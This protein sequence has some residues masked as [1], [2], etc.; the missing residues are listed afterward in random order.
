MA[1]IT[2]EGFYR[3]D[4]YGEA[5]KEN[6]LR[7]Q[8]MTEDEQTEVEILLVKHTLRDHDQRASLRRTVHTD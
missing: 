2:L 7:G 4:R 8:M 1:R 3:R 6:L 5:T